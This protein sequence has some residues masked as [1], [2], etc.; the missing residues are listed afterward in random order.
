MN[1]RF[2]DKSLSVRAAQIRELIFSQTARNSGYIFTGN[3]ISTLFSVVATM[4]VSRSLGPT[5]FGKL[6]IFTSLYTTI[7]GITDFGLGTASVKIISSK[8]NAS[9][10]DAGISMKVIIYAELIS[11]FIVALVG[12]LFAKQIAKFLGGEDLVFII[13]MAFVAGTFA[14]AGAFIAP[15]FSSFQQFLKSALFGVASSIV[16]TLGVAILFSIALLNLNNV[17]LLYTAIN[18]CAFFIGF[19]LVPRNFLI[20]SSR[21]ENINAAKEIFHF[22]K[23]VLLSYVATVITSSLDM[24][25]LQRY[26]GSTQVGLYAAAQQ[27]A[28][29]LPLLIGALT[30][31]LL[32]R[33]SRMQSKQE[34]L[35]YAKK[36]MLA[37]IAL[38]CVAIPALLLAPIIVGI[39]YGNKFGASIVYFQV[40]ALGYMFALLAN[41][42]SLIFYAKNRPKVVTAVNYINLI[43][44]VILNVA[45]IPRFGAI[46][47]AICFA[48]NSLIAACILI[49]LSMREI[50]R[51]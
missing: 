9:K 21:K 36:V 44:I 35:S 14:S 20:T 15:F 51:S 45:I 6:A 39:V 13:R 5:N 22:S 8:L 28:M 31:A 47:A 48:V 18:I 7:L 10:R 4:M 42:I 40:L 26:W 30:T 16:K 23:W 3:I 19:L 1:S 27:L 24:F 41:P 50:H 25:I 32:P 11:G 33:I 17:I 46:G 38:F 2:L 12:L 34:Y 29:L 49:P 37:S 43:I